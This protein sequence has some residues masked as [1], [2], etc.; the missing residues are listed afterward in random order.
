[1][2]QGN[3][4]DLRTQAGARTV[5]ITPG[6]S[7]QYMI[8]SEQA[9][10]GGLFNYVR[11]IFLN[12]FVN[13]TRTAGSGMLPIWADNFASAVKSI[14][15]NTPMDGTLIDPTVMSGMVAKNLHNFVLNGYRYEGLFQD[16]ILAAS[17]TVTKRLELYIPF[18]QKWNP[19]PDQF[20]RWLGWLND[21]ILEIIA[22]DAADPFGA[23]GA[24]TDVINNV[25]FEAALDMVP[26]PEIIIPP[27]V[28]L[29]RYEVGANA[30][31][32]G[33][34]LINVG[35]AGALQGVE[36]ASRL[37]GMYFSHQAGGFI[38]SGTANQISS[39]TMPWRD[40]KQSL[41]LDGFFAR[42]LQDSHNRP[43]HGQPTSGAAITDIFDTAAPYPMPN[44]AADSGAP[45]NGTL[46]SSN[47]RF[48]PLVWP[49][50]DCLV[51]Y[52]QKVK[53]NYPIDM[54]FNTNQS[55]VFRVYTHELKVP[56]D[57]KCS[58]YLASMGINPSAV[59]LVPKLGRKNFKNQDPS[60]M[61]GVPRSVIAVKGA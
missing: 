5:T 12:V 3:Q 51:S 34:T 49:S 7:V 24:G 58:E 23:Q 55:N 39:I 10:I 8:N 42:W 17:A 50:R 53:G 14:N 61:W 28:V 22:N 20:A 56:S 46:A 36:D 40:Q 32:N 15:L 11:G 26:W 54:V 37:V 52:L 33:P 29:R 47:A 59:T 21:G 30:S 35:T 4:I 19:W 45:P 1:M 6:N 31:S 2:R 48:T 16:P 43:M 41:F 25:T 44:S 13:I 18:S 9:R 60:K 38:G 27:H 57:D